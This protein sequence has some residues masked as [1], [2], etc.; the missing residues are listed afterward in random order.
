ML[1][2]GGSIRHVSRRDIRRE[3]GFRALLGVAVAAAARRAQR[4]G[5]ALVHDILLLGIG[6]LAVDAELAGCAGLAAFD[7]EGGKEGPL[8]E[9]GD[10]DR[11]L[12]AA[13]D[14]DLLRQPAAMAAGAARVGSQLLVVET[15]RRD[16]LADLDRGRAHVR[17]P[18]ETGD[19]VA[20][21]V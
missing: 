12:A 19:A 14:Q 11:R 13:L 20:L 18:R 3:R 6:L 5:V 16:V 8:G 10:G 17:R 7:A 4:D 1:A 21:R 15:Q 2:I 9:E